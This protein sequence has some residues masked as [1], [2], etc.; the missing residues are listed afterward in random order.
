MCKIQVLSQNQCQLYEA[1][2]KGSGLGEHQ[3]EAINHQAK[4]YAQL[5][6]LV[7]ILLVVLCI[8]ISIPLTIQYGWGKIE[9]FFAYL[10]I[11]PVIFCYT[12]YAIT[13]RKL[14]PIGIYKMII[15]RKRAKLYK[16][17][18]FQYIE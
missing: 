12:Y 17:F 7:A 10:N 4:R 2:L 13:S 14:D 5:T 9:P 15:K 8:S 16:A 18:G 6:M 11:I 3:R 1:Y